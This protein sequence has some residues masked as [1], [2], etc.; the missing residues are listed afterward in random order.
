MKI[1]SKHGIMKVFTDKIDEKTVSQITKMG[2]SNLGKNAHIRIMP[3]CHAGKGC[4]IGTTMLITDKICP[5]LIGV[6]IGCGVNLIK[7][8][9]KLKNRLKELDNVIRNHIP[10][11][12]GVHKVIKEYDFSQLKCWDSLDNG[13]KQR[14]QRSLGSL[15]GGNHFIEAYSNAISVHSGSRNIGSMIAAYYQKIAEKTIKE[16]SI[17]N[18]TKALD[19]IQ[20]ELREEWIAN[21]KAVPIIE[22]DLSY[23]TGGNMQDYLHDM[24]LVQA[25]AVKNRLHM[26][27]TIVDNM[28][29]TIEEEITSTHNFIDTENMILRKGAISAQKDEIL[30]IPL[31]M[32]DGILI[33]K[34]KGNEEWNFSA[35]H[36]AGRL[37]SRTKARELFKLTDYVKTM[38]GIYSTCIR[39]DTIDEAPFAYK[40]YKEIMKNIEPTVEIIERVIPIFNFKA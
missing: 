38:N 26:L 23:L 4:A 5:N 11:G 32:R 15:G 21:N 13:T 33:C 25:F 24:K 18:W 22:N 14:S 28:N 17:K 2:N 19:E 7:I 16:M 27:K 12:M 35:P 36:G 39:K 37:Y 6:D 3:D 40:N 29:L 31:N 10:F 20:P 9:E 8:K 1:E 34:G 30:V